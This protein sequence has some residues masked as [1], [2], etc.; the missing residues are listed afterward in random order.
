M[1]E[2]SCW[3][4]FVGIVLLAFWLVELISLMNMTDDQFPGR[5]DKPTWAVIL[6]FTL[7]LGAFAFWIWKIGTGA[8][9]RATAVAGEVVQLI[10]K[11]ASTDDS[12][13]ETKPP[14]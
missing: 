1:G 7:V 2:L 14:A 11:H 5:F 13:T 12:G 3:M 8:D 10:N 6:V 9:Q 4:F